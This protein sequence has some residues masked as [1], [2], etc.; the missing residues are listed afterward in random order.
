[1]P[2][3]PDILD[4]MHRL[5]DAAREKSLLMRAIGGLAVR[6]KSGDLQRFFSREYR[7]LDF[8]VP[9]NERRR[10]EPFFLELGYEA[11]RQFKL[12]N[13]SKRQI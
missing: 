9:E 10:I 11:N 2:I 6:V 5:L 4:E 1:M 7:D 12:L 8:V 3:L 13:G